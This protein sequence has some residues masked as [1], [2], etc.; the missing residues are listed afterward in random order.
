MYNQ[1]EYIQTDQ[2]EKTINN[3]N[4]IKTIMCTN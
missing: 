3:F 1:D 4:L 2:E